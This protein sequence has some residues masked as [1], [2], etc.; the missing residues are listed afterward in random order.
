MPVKLRGYGGWIEIIEGDGGF[1][2]QFGGKTNVLTLGVDLG[3]EENK[4]FKDDPH[5][6]LA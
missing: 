4:E 5:V 1:R 3:C 2:I 6:F